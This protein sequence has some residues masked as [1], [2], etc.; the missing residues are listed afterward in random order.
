M[1]NYKFFPL[2]VPQIINDVSMIPLY[3][4]DTLQN[5]DPHDGLNDFVVA[6]D[7]VD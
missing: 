5:R 2:L 6:T 7:F 4:L 3:P 1:Q